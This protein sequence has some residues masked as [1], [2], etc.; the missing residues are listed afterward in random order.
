M[1]NVQ[2]GANVNVHGLGEM[3][4][5]FYTGPHKSIPPFW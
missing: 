1:R 3:V 4:V 2:G 5:N